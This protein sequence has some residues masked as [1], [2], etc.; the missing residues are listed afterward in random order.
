MKKSNQAGSTTVLQKWRKAKGGTGTWENPEP[1]ATMNKQQER[2]NDGGRVAEATLMLASPILKG[3][4]SATAHGLDL[5]THLH[6]VE[7]NESSLHVLASRAG[8]VGKKRRLVERR[9]AD[10]FTDRAGKI[11]GTASDREYRTEITTTVRKDHES[12]SG[13][14]QFARILADRMR[15]MCEADLECRRLA[16]AWKLVTTV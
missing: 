13:R 6:E 1:R 10:G 5:R 15:R 4:R 12:T 7:E 16:P 14:L 3:K 2:L 8:D 11:I 9:W